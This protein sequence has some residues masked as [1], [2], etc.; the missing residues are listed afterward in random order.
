MNVLIFINGG[1]S[2]ITNKKSETS[3]SSSGAAQGYVKAAVSIS[4]VGTGY[5]Q[6]KIQDSTL[7]LSYG[8]GANGKLGISATLTGGVSISGGGNMVNT[9]YYGQTYQGP[10]FTIVEGKFN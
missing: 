3:S 9:A 5:A 8:G 6:A 7:T 2:K 4:A 10:Y 1:S